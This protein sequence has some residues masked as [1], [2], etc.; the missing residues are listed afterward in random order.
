MKDLTGKSTKKVEFSLDSITNNTVIRKQVEG[1][2]EEIVLC[3]GKIKNEQEAIRD[4]MSEAKDSLGI[5]R[6]ILNKLVKENIAPGSIESEVH[7]LETVQEISAV[8]EAAHA[9]P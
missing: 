6:K 3:K 5:P 2:V 7:D 9:Q 8:I 4:I 1:F